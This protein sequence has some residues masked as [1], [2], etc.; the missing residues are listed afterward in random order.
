M[1]FPENVLGSFDWSRSLLPR[2]CDKEKQKY[3]P[4]WM[5]EG[6]TQHR[7]LAARVTQVQPVLIFSSPAL[8]MFLIIFS[9]N[10][11]FFYSTRVRN[12]EKYSLFK[13]KSPYEL[14]YNSSPVPFELHLLLGCPVQSQPI[15]GF[16]ALLKDFFRD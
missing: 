10:F 15:D 16:C 1:P 8:C 2:F 6:R 12:K 7:H 13:E 14:P 9:G 3:E 11:R 5:Q 4:C